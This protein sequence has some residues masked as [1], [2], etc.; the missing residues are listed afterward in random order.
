MSSVLT[1]CHRPGLIYVLSNA[2][3]PGLVKIGMTERTAVE[4]AAELSTAT[5]VPTAFAVEHEERVTDC[6]AAEAAVHEALTQFRVNG[7][8][9]F[10][11]LTVPHAVDKV[12]EACKAFVLVDHVRRL[13]VDQ[14][15]GCPRDG[16]SSVVRL[17]EL[18]TYCIHGHLVQRGEERTLPSMLECPRCGSPT[19]LSAG[20]GF[21]VRGHSVRA[22]GRNASAKGE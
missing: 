20:I 17:G 14:L 5:G 6:R 3:M 13:S 7:G 9:E 16:C 8:R 4:R 12:R 2:S 18:P 21:C 1:V 19:Q 22:R 11:Q 15:V 10:F